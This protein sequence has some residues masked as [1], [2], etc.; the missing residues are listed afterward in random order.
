[1]NDQADQNE[2]GQNLQRRLQPVFLPERQ[3]Q[4]VEQ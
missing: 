4:H 1:M 3:Q 2:V